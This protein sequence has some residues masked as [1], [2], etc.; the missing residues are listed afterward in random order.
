MFLA[1]ED[2]VKNI[3]WEKHSNYINSPI[4]EIISKDI[5]S[6]IIQKHSESLLPKQQEKSED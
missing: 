5:S 1:Y 4:K 3:V 2:E 6:E